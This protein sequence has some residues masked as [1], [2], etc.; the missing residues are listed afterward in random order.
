MLATMVK[1]DP[2]ELLARL[3]RRQQ[4][5][6]HVDDRLV[7]EVQRSEAMYLFTIPTEREY[8]RLVW[9]SI[10]DTRPLTPVGSPRTLG[11]CVGRLQPYDWSFR[12]LA[13]E[14]HPWFVTCVAIDENFHYE[15][16]DWIALVMLNE[17]ERNE[18]PSGTYYIFDGVHKSIVLAKQVLRRELAYE[19]I[20]ALLLT[21]RR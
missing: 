5:D 13:D 10:A 7:Q 3:E 16:F 1:V 11:H 2:P 4:S 20:E 21:P 14:G 9:Q 15:R 12:R 6:L 18:S 19:P 8:L 17:H